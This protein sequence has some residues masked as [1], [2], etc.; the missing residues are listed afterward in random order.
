M[1][2]QVGQNPRHA[3]VLRPEENQIKLSQAGGFG[4]WQVPVVV[5]PE[6]RL[7]GER[8]SYSWIFKIDLSG[9]IEKVAALPMY[10]PGTSRARTLTLED[11][12]PYYELYREIHK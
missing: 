11:T 3:I 12:R 10:E 5:F 6:G 2:K 9:K 4:Y 1:M 8:D 7:K